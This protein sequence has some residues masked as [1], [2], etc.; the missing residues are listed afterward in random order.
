MHVGNGGCG[1]GDDE[2]VRGFRQCVMNF[3]EYLRTS[4]ST[5]SNLMTWYDFSQRST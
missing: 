2:V 5:E 1:S 3:L 4:A